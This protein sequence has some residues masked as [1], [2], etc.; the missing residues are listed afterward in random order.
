MQTQQYNIEMLKRI[1]KK[2]ERENEYLKKQLD[3]FTQ[4]CSS[5]RASLNSIVGVPGKKK[6]DGG[7]RDKVM[8]RLEGK[9]DKNDT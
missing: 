3:F 8:S 6:E 1:N 7:F 9:V 2:K 5:K 4:A